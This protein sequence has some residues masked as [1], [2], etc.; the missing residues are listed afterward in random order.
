MRLA[1]FQNRVPEIVIWLLLG[2]AVATAGVVGYNNGLGNRR[3][4]FGALTL[5]VLVVVI[6]RVIIDLDRPRH[7]LILV[8]QQSMIN[9]QESLNKDIP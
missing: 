6:I 3:H 8:S 7:G 5:I 4:V 2:V 1:A 9:L